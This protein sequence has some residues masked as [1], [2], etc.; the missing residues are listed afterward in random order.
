MAQVHVKGQAVLLLFM[1]LLVAACLTLHKLAAVERLGQIKLR[2][3]FANQTDRLHENLTDSDA[4]SGPGRVIV[5]Q[6]VQL[7]EAQGRATELSADS[8]AAQADQ[9]KLA[10]LEDKLSRTE[11][12]LAEAKDALATT[13]VEL[14]GV[15]AELASLQF[16]AVPSA[17]AITPASTSPNPL[18]VVT[19]VD[20]SHRRAAVAFLAS[21]HSQHLISPI[22]VLMVI[23]DKTPELQAITLAWLQPLIKFMRAIHD[24]SQGS[25]W[26]D[27]AIVSVRISAQR[28]NDQS[29]TAYRTQCV[30]NK[31]E[32]DDGC[33]E[34]DT[35]NECG[36]ALTD[37]GD[38][39]ALL[40][41]SRSHCA[42]L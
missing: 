26:A 27:E 14:A 25:A 40:D 12:Q 35:C 39:L 31:P 11:N 34:S 8:S 15:T 33:R 23:T 9:T 42:R 17:S 38:M 32:F 16:Q 4:A 24:A 18:C 19:R 3:D 10:E 30:A 6:N 1:V 36:Y 37:I 41:S 5:Q 29:N 13:K 21:L 28:F 7:A 2:R 20:Q 22:E